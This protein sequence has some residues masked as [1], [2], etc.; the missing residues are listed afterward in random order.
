MGKI[1]QVRQFHLV[2]EL[3][4]QTF[5]TYIGRRACGSRKVSNELTVD[6][7]DYVTRMG[8]CRTGWG[9]DDEFRGG[10]SSFLSPNLL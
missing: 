4:M 8:G 3:V 1:S 5:Y 9:Y 7:R 10:D 6:G 2:G